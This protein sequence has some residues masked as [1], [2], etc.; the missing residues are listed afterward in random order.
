[1]PKNFCDEVSFS[2]TNTSIQVKDNSKYSLHHAGKH[3]QSHKRAQVY[4]I[5]LDIIQE[6]N[7]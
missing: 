3:D 2:H 4:L 1:V 6:S 7:P 5:L